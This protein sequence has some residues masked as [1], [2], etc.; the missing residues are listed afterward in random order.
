MDGLIVRFALSTH[1]SQL[2]RLQILDPLTLL[3]DGQPI[4][5]SLI[6]PA[7][8]LMQAFEG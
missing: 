6:A 3:V 8:V 7:Q 1:C 5:P 4:R 2:I